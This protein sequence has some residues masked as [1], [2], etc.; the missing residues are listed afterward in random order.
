MSDYIRVPG[1]DTGIEVGDDRILVA[2]V[3]ADDLKDGL[4][5]YVSGELLM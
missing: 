4:F 3:S 1:G 2:G 5:V